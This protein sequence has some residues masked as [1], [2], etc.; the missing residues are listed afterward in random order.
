[1]R[2][3]AESAVVDDAADA[4]VL[5]TADDDHVDVGVSERGEAEAFLASLSERRGGE[6]VRSDGAL[7]RSGDVPT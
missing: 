7:N 1:M 3:L 2:L 5:E 4:A 6:S